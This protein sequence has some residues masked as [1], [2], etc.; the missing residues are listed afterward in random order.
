MPVSSIHNGWR[1]SPANSRLDVYYRGTRIGHFNATT[2]QSVLAAEAVT[3]LEA[4]TGLTV[5]AGNHTNTAGDHRV[6]A[7]NARLGVVSAFA[8]TEPTSAYVMKEGT[9]P[10]GAIATSGAVFCTTAGATLSK[11]IAA[12]TVSTIQT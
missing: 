6:T 12:G 4:G 1:F 9:N 11:I 5:S 8:T 10:V 2:M 7:G 3:T